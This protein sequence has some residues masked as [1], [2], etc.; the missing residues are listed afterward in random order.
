MLYTAFEPTVGFV[1]FNS[2]R[3][4][5]AFF[6][7]WR[8]RAALA[9]ATDST[10]LVEA[11]LGT[12]VVP[13][14]N[15]LIPGGWAWTPDVT[16]PRFDYDTAQTVLARARVDRPITFTLLSP[17]T[18]RMVSL[19]ETMA[20]QW[21]AL[22]GVGV[23]VETVDAGTLLAR[24]RAREFGA[25]I[26]ELSLAGMA[27]P[28]PYVF[29]HQGQITNGQNYGGVDDGPISEALEQ[30]RSDPNGVNRTTWYHR[31]Q[32]RFAERIPAIPLY[33]PVYT[34]GVD[35]RVQG[36]QLGLLSDPSDRFRSLGMWYFKAP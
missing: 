20:A 16:W 5:T 11:H 9:Y 2:M 30:A 12:Q 27:D 6:D 1:I 36:V 31:F 15:P 25:A 7:D 17:D 19:A 13:A 29:W 26:V 22:D 8:F 3:E 18:P 4:E 24:V 32:Q 33:Y 21:S 28:D 35:S 23:S 14:S 10:G 34:Y